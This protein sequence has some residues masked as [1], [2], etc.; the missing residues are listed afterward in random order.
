MSF[1]IPHIWEAISNFLKTDKGKEAIID[2]VKENNLWDENLIKE[3]EEY[4]NQTYNQNK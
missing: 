3:I 4:Y 2:Y 1:K